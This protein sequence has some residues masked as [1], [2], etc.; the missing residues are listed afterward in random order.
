MSIK[1]GQL[2]AVSAINEI[3]VPLIGTSTAGEAPKVTLVVGRAWSKKSNLCKRGHRFTTENTILQKGGKKCRI[4]FNLT[5][6]RLRRRRGGKTMDEYLAPFTAARAKRPSRDEIR[7]ENR[8][9]RADRM[10]EFRRNN[11]MWGKSSLKAKLKKAF[12][13]AKTRGIEFDITVDDFET[14]LPTH[15]EVLGIALCYDGGDGSNNASIDRIDSTKGYVT[16]NVRIISLR[17]NTLKNNGTDIAIRKTH[18]EMFDL[19][20]THMKKREASYAA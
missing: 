7:A 5:Q 15:C 20:K 1:Y 19:V 18:A 16:G 14:P 3:G 8:K 9:R 17:A 6:E 2:G 11:I 13:G 12:H 4:C 10:A